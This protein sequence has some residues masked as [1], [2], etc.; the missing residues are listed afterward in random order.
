MAV[1][2]SIKFGFS[3]TLFDLQ[4]KAFSFSSRILVYKLLVTS[5]HLLQEEKRTTRSCLAE[6]AAVDQKKH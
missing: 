1:D 2:M 3:K 5:G 4:H 6:N